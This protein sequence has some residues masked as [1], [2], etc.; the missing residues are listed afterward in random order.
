MIDESANMWY[1]RGTQVD[2]CV[3]RP[4]LKKGMVR[5]HIIRLISLTKVIK[6]RDAQRII[7]GNQREC[8][9]NDHY[10]RRS[11]N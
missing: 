9:S 6:V 1:W 3:K 2:G 4:P 10:F 7:K 11:L 5:R 8:D